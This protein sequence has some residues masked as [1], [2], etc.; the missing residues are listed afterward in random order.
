MYIHRRKRTG[1]EE[2]KTEVV[3]M[4]EDDKKQEKTAEAAEGDLDGIA[5]K[6]GKENTEAE[7]REAIGGEGGEAED[8][9]PP[10]GG[11]LEVALIYD[12][13]GSAVDEGL[14]DWS[15]LTEEE[16]VSANPAKG[17][18]KIQAFIGMQGKPVMDVDISVTKEFSDGEREFFRGKT[19]GD[20]MIDNITLPA[21]ERGNSQIPGS[22]N[23]YAT[24]K[25]TAAHPSYLASEFLSV[26]VFAGVKS[27]QPIVLR[28]L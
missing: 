3:L 10:E 20:G 22:N 28:S 7:D 2:N 21:P 16:F 12:E 27:I 15:L 4:K 5:E 13:E 11:A 19:N 6:A 1:R 9:T 8:I 26:P 14:I 24:Y 25:I 23:P 18:L 17:L